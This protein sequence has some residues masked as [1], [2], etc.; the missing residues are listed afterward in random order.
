MAFGV[1]SVSGEDVSSS[2]ACFPGGSAFII[3]LI[4]IL[5]VCGCFFFFI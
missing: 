3:F 1:D 2:G 5:I 4:L